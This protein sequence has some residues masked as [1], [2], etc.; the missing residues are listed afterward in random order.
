MKKV[1]QIISNDLELIFFVTALLYLYFL[2]FNGS[3]FSFC[4]L[5]NLGFKYCP[6]CGLGSSISEVMHFNIKESFHTHPL[7]LF[8]FFVI[9]FRILQLIINKFRSKKHGKITTNDT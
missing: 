8:A 4:I 5:D 6:G 3:G 7:G 9:L 2:P 1:L